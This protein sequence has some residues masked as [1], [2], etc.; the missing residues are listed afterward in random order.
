MYPRPPQSPIFDFDAVGIVG[1]D[2]LAVGEPGTRHLGEFV[3]EP[4]S[5]RVVP[6]SVRR[7]L[8]A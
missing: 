8:R 4:G 7:G 5:V 1:R 6:V 3:G 2:G